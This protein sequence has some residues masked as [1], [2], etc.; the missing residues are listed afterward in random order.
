MSWDSGC[1]KEC[2]GVHL[3]E[4][5]MGFMRI[6]IMENPYDEGQAR[7]RV[8]WCQKEMGVTEEML[9]CARRNE[10]FSGCYWQNCG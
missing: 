3:D 9:D 1:L 6:G 2:E 4:K 7:G 5:L 8:P 10:C